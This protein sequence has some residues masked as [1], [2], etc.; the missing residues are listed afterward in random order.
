MTEAQLT[1]LRE[2]LG[3]MKSDAETLYN[4]EDRLIDNSCSTSREYYETARDANEQEYAARL[5]AIESIKE[6]FGIE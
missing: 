3:G 4:H 6:L 5:E 2:F 1:A